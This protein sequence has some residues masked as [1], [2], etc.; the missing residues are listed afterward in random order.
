MLPIS[1]HIPP[2]PSIISGSNNTRL[3]LFAYYWKQNNVY[4]IAWQVSI[5]GFHSRAELMWKLGFIRFPKL[6]STAISGTSYLQGKPFE[7]VFQSLLEDNVQEI[8]CIFFSIC[9]KTQEI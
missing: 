5:N 2:I 7:V 8:K 9:Y 3:P 1:L 4:M 6:L